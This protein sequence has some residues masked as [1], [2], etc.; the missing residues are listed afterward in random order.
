MTWVRFFK[1]LLLVVLL[2]LPLASRSQE[3]FSYATV[4][5]R[6]TETRLDPKQTSRW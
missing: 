5:E 1:F 2:G 4:A 3:D 6:Y